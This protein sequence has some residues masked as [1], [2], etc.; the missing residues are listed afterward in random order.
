MVAFFQGGA[1]MP[2]HEKSTMSLR[3]EFAQLAQAP[4]ANV[5]ELCRRT[6]ISRKTAYKWLDRFATGG[7]E[8]LAD[9]SRRPR[10]SPRQT[11]PEIEQCV[12]ELRDEH[13][14][15]GGRKLK[16]RLEDLGHPRIP[17]ASTLTAILHRHGHVAPERSAQHRPWRRF[18]HDAP[19]RLWQMDFK[20]HFPLSDGGRCQP[21]TVLDDHSRFNLLLSACADQQRSTVQERL[22]VAFRHYGLP[23][24][25]TMDNGPPWGCEEAGY[26]RLTVWL[27]RLGIG[28]GH[29]RPYHPQTQGKD[30]RFHRTLQ[31]ELLQ[32]S[33]F[34]SLAQVQARFDAWRATYN[35]QRPHQALGLATPATRYRVSPR[36]FPET[37]PLIEYAEGDHVRKVHQGGFVDFRGRRFKVSKAFV[38]QTIAI[39]PTLEDGLLDVYFC[40]KSIATFDLREL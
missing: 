10:H 31:A 7:A 19:N 15:W 8:A 3:H 22:T 33:C 4:G 36:P 39:R 13:P 14:A 20:G 11:C 5:S 37:L 25:M 32:G 24:R 16:R 38:G 9:R 2:W 27:L 6:G 21:L 40:R 17:S 18:E 34:R 28:V 35:L 1:P 30:E 23:E 12:L 26:T 29:S